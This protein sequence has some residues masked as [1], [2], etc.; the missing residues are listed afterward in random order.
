MES[1]PQNVLFILTDQ[2]RYDLTSPTGPPVETDALDDLAE[3]G[4]RFTHAFTPISICSSARASLLTGLYAH[5]HGVLNNVHEQDAIQADLSPDIPTFGELLKDAGYE[6]SYVGKWHVGRNAHPGDFG[7]EYLGG[8]DEHHDEH[9][10]GG[11]REYQHDLGIDPESIEVE[12]VVRTNDPGEETIIAGRTSIPP[13]ATRAYY[14]AELTIERIEALADGGDEPWFHRADFLG[15]H[16]PYIVPEPYASMYDPDEIEAWGSFRETFTGKPQVH[17]NYVTYRGVDHLEWADWAEAVSLY[18]GFMHLIDDQIDRIL[19]ALE[20]AGLREDTLIVHASDHGDFTGNHRQFNKGP[21]MYDDT[22][23][24]PLIVTGPDV[25]EGRECDELVSLIDL[26]P[27]FLEAGGV[28][29]PEDIHGRSLWPLLSGDPEHDSATGRDAV[30]AEYHGDEFGLYSQR[31]ARTH[32]YKYVYNA[33]DVDEL[34]DLEEDPH[35][36]QN[37]IEHPHYQKVREDQRR[38]LLD[39]MDRTDDPIHDWT[40]LHLD[41]GPE[42]EGPG[43]R[44]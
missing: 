4:V 3:Q 19:T 13:E 30:F 37:L 44:S 29:P 8:S 24:I 41:T 5:Q 39:W 43:G 42:R 18:L 16:H 1:A 22:Y 33:P 12:P 17:E 9:L 36:L 7:F 10:E 35:E 21:L 34:Y 32:R 25:A 11:F 23:R 20:D 28:E 26:T 27:T 6:N 38:R 40:R 31:M 2:E 15:P 14:L